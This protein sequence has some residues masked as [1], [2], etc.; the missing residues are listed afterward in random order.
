MILYGYEIPRE[1]VLEKTE[2]I[3]ENE[4]KEETGPNDGWEG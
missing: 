2:E 1:T 3:V 4:R